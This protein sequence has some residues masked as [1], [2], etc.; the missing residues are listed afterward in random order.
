MGGRMEATS[1]RHLLKSA[2]G[3]PTPTAVVAYSAAEYCKVDDRVITRG[4]KTSKIRRE[5]AETIPMSP[6][7]P[8]TSAKRC[9]RSRYSAN[10]RSDDE[11]VAA[12]GST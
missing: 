5:P 9:F 1:R 4:T 12:R 6:E 2:D 11:D 7:R 3:G 8:M 10:Q